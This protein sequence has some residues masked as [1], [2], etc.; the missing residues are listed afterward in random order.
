VESVKLFVIVTTP[1]I[2]EEFGFE[3]MKERNLG[4]VERHF[5]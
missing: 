2:G 5:E 4:R 3:M 1:C